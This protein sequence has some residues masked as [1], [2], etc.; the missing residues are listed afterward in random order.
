MSKSAFKQR[1]S[2]DWSA[3]HDMDADILVGGLFELHFRVH[4]RFKAVAGNQAREIC[5][6]AGS[7]KHGN[8]S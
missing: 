4:A 5:K 6:A 7:S 2:I 3:L 1:D 8:Y